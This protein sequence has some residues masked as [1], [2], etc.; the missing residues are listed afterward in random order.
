MKRSEIEV[1]LNSYI[2]YTTGGN[3]LWEK[4]YSFTVLTI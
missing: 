4:N 1:A 3:P 2:S